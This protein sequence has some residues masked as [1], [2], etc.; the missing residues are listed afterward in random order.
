MTSGGHSP[1][2]GLAAFARASFRAGD[3]YDA[4]E[5]YDIDYAGYMAEDAFYRRCVERVVGDD[6]AMIELGAG[7]GRLCLG[8]AAT[9]TRVHAVEPAAPMLER[10]LE[11]ASAQEGGVVTGECATAANFVGPQNERTDLITF[12]FNSLLHIHSRVELLKS[13]ANVH[14][15]LD[16][17]GHFALDITAPYWDAMSRKEVVWG[18]V[19]ERTHPRTGVRILTCDR[20]RYDGASKTLTTEFRF[21]TATESEGV[22]L[23]ITQ[24]MWTFQ[25]VQAV[26]EDAGFVV[27]ERFGDVDFAPFLERSPRLLLTASKR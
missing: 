23:Q 24:R 2:G 1:T 5:W 3:L 14:A 22:D 25:E 11:K 21:L 10:L 9:G 26:L 15:C 8:Y 27:F 7:T 12:P 4:A 19:D 20:A 13:F 17:G 6:G 16:D 18:R